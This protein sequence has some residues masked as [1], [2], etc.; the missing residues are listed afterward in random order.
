MFIITRII[1]FYCNRCRRAPLAEGPLGAC[2]EWSMDQKCSMFRREK[3]NIENG[4]ENTL[5]KNAKFCTPRSG[6]INH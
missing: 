3:S 2:D 6:Y 1:I 5:K 4:G